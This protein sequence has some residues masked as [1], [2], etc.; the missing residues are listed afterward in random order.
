[1]DEIKH[2]GTDKAYEKSRLVIQAYNDPRKNLILTQSPTVQRVSQRLILALAVTLKD[3]NNRTPSLYLRDISQAYIQSRTPLARDFY[4]K[5]P[6]E[7]G[8]PPNTILKLVLP[9]YG[10]PEA[11]NHW[12]QTYHRYHREKLRMD[13]STYDP[14]LLFTKGNNIGIIGLQTDDTLLLAD[15][16]FAA[17]EEREL[18]KVGF[19]TKEREE[20]TATNPIKFN[21]G[22]L[23][24]KGN[25]LTL[26]QGQHCQNLRPVSLET[27]DLTSARGVVRKQIPTKGQ[28]VAQRARGAYVA[29]VCQPEAAFD[30]SSAAQ[31]TE[32]TNDDIRKLNKRLEWQKENPLRGLT[33]V[34][35]KT[36]TPLKLVVFT[37]SSFANNADYSSQIGYVI[38]LADDED[39]A[40]VLHWSS[41]K[42]KRV[43]RSTLASELY[44][45]VNGFDI[46]AAIKK[47]IENITKTD[48]LPLLLCTDSKSLYECLVKLGTT[49]EKRLMVDIMCLRQS[50][51][52]REITEI[53]WIDGD[54]NPA[55]A[56]T[57]SRPCQALKDLIDSNRI[58]LRATGWVERAKQEV[59]PAEGGNTTN[60]TKTKSSQCITGVPPTSDSDSYPPAPPQRRTPVWGAVNTT[61]NTNPDPAGPTRAARAD[62]SEPRSISRTRATGL[63]VATSNRDIDRGG[64]LGRTA[65]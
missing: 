9:L 2:P 63:A 39:N 18:Q 52:R 50:Y 26:T 28:Y 57:K 12:F 35:L 17:E 55:D 47:T 1:V 56:M 42:C 3:N 53:I 38:A 49:H 4:A 23:T 62:Q 29:T 45:M 40:N 14:C 27:V 19:L 31:V 30:L 60:S 24:M 65:E 5:P 10:V 8:L 7:L 61:R 37:D 11:G 36:G 43:T 21:G 22:Q 33:F 58:N 13:Q 51:E 20:L 48:H 32:P 41:T 25:S 64:Q 59:I 44:G 46:G 15:R 6:P 16:S 54:S 34:P